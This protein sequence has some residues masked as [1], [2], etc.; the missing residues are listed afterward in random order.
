MEQHRGRISVK[1]EIGQYTEF[2]LAF[3]AVPSVEM[4]PEQES[5]RGNGQHL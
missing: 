2:S 5:W 1:S 4:A 3:P